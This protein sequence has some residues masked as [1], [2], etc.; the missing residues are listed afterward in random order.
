MQDARHESKY[1]EIHIN[2]ASNTS[3]HTHS[4]HTHKYA[5]RNAKKHKTNQATIN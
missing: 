5:T 2:I 1:I 4:N 3:I